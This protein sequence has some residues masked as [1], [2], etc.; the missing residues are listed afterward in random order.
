MLCF[1]RNKHYTLSPSF[2][3]VLVTALVPTANSSHLS[4]PLRGA[5]LNGEEGPGS[6]KLLAPGDKLRIQSCRPPQ[7]R[8][9][10]ERKGGQYRGAP[11]PDS[12]VID[13]GPSFL[14]RRGWG[15]PTY[16]LTLPFLTHWPWVPHSPGCPAPGFCFWLPCLTFPLPRRCFPAKATTCFVSLCLYPHLREQFA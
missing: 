8:Q 1:K 5:G 6:R 15:K 4:L 11:L 7:R 16:S 12:Y 2:V 3:P 14:L 9:G 10:W 13:V